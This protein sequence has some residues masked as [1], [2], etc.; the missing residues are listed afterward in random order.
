MDY[1]QILAAHDGLQ[2]RVNELEEALQKIL[3]TK[4]AFGLDRSAVVGS[5]HAISWNVHDIARKALG[6]E[7]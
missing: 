5:K 7:A 3:A 6:E 1:A 4:P 2:D